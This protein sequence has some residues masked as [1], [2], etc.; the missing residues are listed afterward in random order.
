MPGEIVK[1]DE[2]YKLY[3]DLVLGSNVYSLEKADIWLA[4]DKEWRNNQPRAITLKETHISSKPPW[5]VKQPHF[6]CLTEKYDFLPEPKHI[7][8]FIGHKRKTLLKIC[9]K[10]KLWT[11]RSGL[12][13]SS[14][15][16]GSMEQIKEFVNELKEFYQNH[17]YVDSDVIDSSEKV[18]KLFQRRRRQG[19]IKKV[20]ATKK[21][22]I[23]YGP[24]KYTCKKHPSRKQFSLYHI[25]DI[26]K[27]IPVHQLTLDE[28]KDI[29]RKYKM[30]EA[31][32]LTGVD[33]STIKVWIKKYGLDI[34]KITNSY[35]FEYD[36]LK[37]L[38][39]MKG[40]P[41]PQKLSIARRYYLNSP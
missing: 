23:N 7:L 12:M 3:S 36:D 28:L 37:K 34:L 22:V 40:K 4:L 1:F 21:Q 19:I 24:L 13:I 27:I 5:R 26:L 30:R 18:K 20:Y 11:W 16:F 10:G 29:N 31:E 38:A 32:Q 41:E 39:E 14:Y 25:E 33:R 6:E 2:I 17:Y 8:I 9:C 35:Q 15:N